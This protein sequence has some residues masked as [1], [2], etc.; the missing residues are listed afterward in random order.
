MTS[1]AFLG[2]WTAKQTDFLI[3][4]SRDSVIQGAIEQRV[5]DEAQAQI[6]LSLG[7][8][9]AAPFVNLANHLREDLYQ[10]HKKLQKQLQFPLI[11]SCFCYAFAKGAELAYL[12]TEG[13]SEFGYSF[14]DAVRG[15]AGAQV[16]EEF[17]ER[18]TFGMNSAYNIF[19]NFQ[20]AVII[21]PSHGFAAGGRWLADVI[22]CGFYWASQVGL[23]YGMALVSL[24]GSDAKETLFAEAER[25]GWL[26]GRELSFIPEIQHIYERAANY[27]L[28]FIEDQDP[29]MRETLAFHVCRY[30]FAKGVEGVI[31]WGASSDGNISVGFHPKHLAGEIETDVPKHL[32]ETVTRALPIGESLFRVHQK[33][34]LDHQNAETAL[35]LHEEL[36]TTLQWIPRLGISYGLFNKYQALR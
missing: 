29:K 21:P 1:L 26:P 35:D 6:V 11:N 24:S 34:I 22:A 18:I 19:C 20:N 10:H 16:S 23:V 15:A 2:E 8:L 27:F 30:L 7:E 13:E 36:K 12:R 4:A 5:L 9:G 32:H 31:L 17:A 33:R 28:D 14:E 3:T 25:Q